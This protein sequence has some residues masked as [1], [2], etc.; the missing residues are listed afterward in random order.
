MDEILKRVKE[1]VYDNT[2]L[3][4]TD[5]KPE[6]ES[7][8]Y[9]AC[10]FLLNEKPV[11][12]RN[13]KTT[14]KKVGQFVTFWKRLGNGPIEP[15]NEVDNFDFFVINVCNN[16]RLGQF[17]FPKS[18]LIKKG[19]ITTEQKEGKR[20]FR[21]Y[22]IWDLAISKQATQTQSWQLEYFY[23]INTLLDSEFIV[24]LYNQE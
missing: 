23:E 16:N 11:I 5:F 15:F 4:I 24:E 3:K 9:E 14:P 20:G 18:I 2:N 19:I 6:K 12:C 13:A 21:V 7:T 1:E 17:V 10:R 8:A 22:P